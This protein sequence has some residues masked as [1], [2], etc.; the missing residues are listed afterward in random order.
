MSTTTQE[1][2]TEGLV[3]QAKS[4][5]ADAASAVQDKSLELK[6]QGRGKLGETL[7]RRTTEMGGQARQVANALRQTSS[8]MTAQADH[9]G[10]QVGQAAEWVAGRVERLGGYLEHTNGDHLLRDAEDFA[11]R[12]PWMVAG[13]GLVA[14]LAA[15]RF[16]KASSE[17]RYESFGSNGESATHP[18]R[19]A[20][21]WEIR[22]AASLG[23][24]PRRVNPVP[25]TNGSDTQG[26]RDRPI[27]EVTGAL[28]RDLA[29]LVR[30]EL[31]LAK[32]EMTEKGR[33]AAPGLGMIGGA[34][35]VALMAA[36]AFTACAVLVLSLFLPAWFSALLVGAALGAL[37]YLLAMRGKDQVGKAGSLIPEKTIETI[38]EDVEWARARATSARK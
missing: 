13:M 7:D 9:T 5:L 38:E 3:E 27:G 14:G 19:H 4:E 16:L 8:Q 20:A 21:R 6:E 31:E 32:A 12:R 2:G 23:R 35:V 36:G 15:S 18:T 17:R 22:A 24:R 34:G 10:Q 25:T 33:V 26:L 37:A 11:R 30:Q 29:L 1:T 28:T